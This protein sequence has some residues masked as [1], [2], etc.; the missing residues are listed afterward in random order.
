MKPFVNAFGDVVS[1]GLT[2]E[3]PR[4]R[5][6]VFK[7]MR[8]MQAQITAIYAVDTANNAQSS[9]QPPKGLFTVYDVTVYHP[10]GSTEQ[11]QRCQAL[12]PLFGGGFNNFFEVLPADP[13]PDATD[14]TVL[15]SFKPGSYVLVAMI[16]GF[17]ANPVIL[18]A[19]P[20][21]NQVAIQK[22]PTSDEL[23]TIKGEFQGY[24]FQINADGSLVMTFNGPR[25][26]QGNF[27]GTNGPT[28]VTMDAQ[29]RF[30]VT[31]NQS[32]TFTIDP[33]SKQMS[34]T[35][36]SVSLVLDQ[37]GSQVTIQCDTATINTNKDATINAQGNVSV[38]SGKDV[39]IMGSP[40]IKLNDAAEPFVLGNQFKSFMSNLLSQISSL[41]VL[42]TAP[43]T[44]SGPP[45]TAAAFSAMS[46][47]LDPLL[48]KSIKGS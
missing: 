38:Q 10:D 32:Q 9:P 1:A 43:G 7:E 47:Q 25:D 48:S 33:Q 16:D 22:R 37:N 14:F 6:A 20:H 23:P 24:Q 8:L 39:S 27:T 34:M 2:M 15:P 46:N 12:Q 45:I 5:H 30:T 4:A 28:T 13:G 41:Q 17:R 42:V 36:G 19:L 3:Q 31:T 11:F 21:P 29:G 44:P 40:N 18:G 35:N 26:D